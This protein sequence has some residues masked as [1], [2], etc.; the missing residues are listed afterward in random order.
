M[1]SS[2]QC[3]D[4][5]LLKFHFFFLS[6]TRRAKTHSSAYLFISQITGTH[7]ATGPPLSSDRSAILCEDTRC[8][9]HHRR[10][11]RRRKILLLDSRVMHK[12]IDRALASPLGSPSR[13]FLGGWA[14]NDIH[15]IRVTS[16]GLLTTRLL[17][18][19]PFTLLFSFSLSLPRPFHLVLVNSWN[20]EKDNNSEGRCRELSIDTDFLSHGKVQS[21]PSK[22]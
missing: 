4:V 15:N 2:R 3:V 22:T 6:E 17:S 12:C 20:D 18:P 10:D 13:P 16:N 9:P 19:P 11:E 8:I 5:V 21:F 7:L 1:P 14:N